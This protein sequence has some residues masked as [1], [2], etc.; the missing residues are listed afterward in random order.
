M[1]KGM[2]DRVGI[3]VVDAVE[4]DNTAHKWTRDELIGIKAEYVKKK[5]E[6]IASRN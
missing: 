5:K 3:G 4:N 2:I 1:R 6:L